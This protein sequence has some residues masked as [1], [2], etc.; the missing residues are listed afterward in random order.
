[1]LPQGTFCTDGPCTGGFK[2]K[3]YDKHAICKNA[4]NYCDRNMTSENY[5]KLQYSFVM[6]FCLCCNILSS[7][8]TKNAELLL[9]RNLALLCLANVSFF[10]NLYLGSSLRLHCCLWKLKFLLGVS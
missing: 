2:N 3:K 6:H 9:L 7:T 5:E 8:M 4:F 1:M 10:K